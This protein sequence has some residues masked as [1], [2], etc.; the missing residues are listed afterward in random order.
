MQITST[1]NPRVKRV[2][3]LRRQRQ[4]LH[5]RVF[6]AE[7][8]RQVNRALEAG[9]ICQEQYICP[10]FLEKPGGADYFDSAEGRSQSTGAGFFEVSAP[11]F[12]KMAYRSKP[13]GVLAIFC[14]PEFTLDSLPEVTDSTLFL[15]V[16]GI[17]KPGNLGA[18]ARTAS[19]VGCSGLLV[20]DSVVDAFNPN[21]IRA[22]TGAVFT[23]PIMTTT[24]GLALDYFL[25]NKIKIFPALVDGS[26]LHTQ[27]D[28]AGATAL[29]IGAEDK[30]LDC[31]WKSAAE[32]SGGHPVRIPMAG[33]AV[34][35]LN[36]SNAAAVLL[37][38]AKRQMG[39]LENS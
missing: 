21:A 4:R 39:P 12:V 28:M 27:A 13:E 23:L 30:G 32:K 8:P 3:K 33:G 31:W 11:V 16:S 15:V 37:F 14:Q 20:V 25:Q 1:S 7:G 36:A 19:A 26:V 2:I 17:E 6:I 34:D 35:S 18:M 9:L 10:K 29:V 38:E 5:E 22:S 24:W